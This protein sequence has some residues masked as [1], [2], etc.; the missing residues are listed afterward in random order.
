MCFTIVT[1]GFLPMTVDA[2][3]PAAYAGERVATGFVGLVA[4]GISMRGPSMFVFGT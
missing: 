1:G 4:L 3:F 2:F